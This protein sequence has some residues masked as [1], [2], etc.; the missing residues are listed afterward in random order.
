VVENGG[1]HSLREKNGKI[2][3]KAGDHDFKVDLFQNEGAVR[4]KVRWETDGIPKEIIP[5]SELFH[6]AD[7]ELDRAKE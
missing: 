2:E 6:R 3:L 5:S 7:P 1:Q 4:L